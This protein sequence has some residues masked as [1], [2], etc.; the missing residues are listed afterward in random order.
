MSGVLTLKAAVAEVKQSV[1][2][3]TSVRA[4]YELRP[5]LGWFLFMTEC[6]RVT[7]RQRPEPEQEVHVT[8]RKGPPEDEQT[9]TSEVVT[10]RDCAEAGNLT[11]FSC[12]SSISVCSRHGSRDHDR[13][14]AGERP[15]T[16]DI[17]L[18]EG[19]GVFSVT[20]A[21]RLISVQGQRT[22]MMTIEGGQHGYA[23]QMADLN[24]SFALIYS[25]LG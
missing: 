13:S 21:L 9:I 23:R 5:S 3:L 22:A 20:L 18:Q 2:Q 16:C 15:V 7:L 17:V 11:S 19:S 1:Y 8:L 14:S 24:C 25:L 10:S 12:L 4:G 6:H